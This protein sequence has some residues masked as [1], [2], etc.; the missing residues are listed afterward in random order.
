MSE[1]VIRVFF[2]VVVIFLFSNL[3]SFA[4]GRSDTT[5]V[6]SDTTNLDALFKKARDLAYDRN[7]AQARRICLKIL[8]KKPNYYEVRTFLGRTYAW[9]KQYDNAR[10]ELSRVL[11]EKE[12]DYEALNALFDVEFWTESYSVAN[13]YLKIALGYYPTSEELLIKKANLQIKLEEK[14]DA[15]L[16]LRR[17]LDIN[18]GNKE[19]ISIMN[20]LEGRKLNNNFQTNFQVDLYDDKNP[21]QLFYAQIGRNF[22]FGSLTMRGNLADKF[23]KQGF[24]YELESYA[25]ITRKLYTN[26]LVGFSSS[27]IFPSEKYLVELYQKLP[28]GF[29]VSL[30][31]RYMKYSKRSFGYTASLSNYYKDYY[32]SVRT[33]ISPKTDSTVKTFQLDKTSVSVIGTIRTYFGDS[34]NYLGLKI[35]SGRSPEE[36]ER[37]DV[38][39]FL[40]SYSIG[41][42]LQKRAIGRWLIKMD[43]TFAKENIIKE[44][45]RF[46]RRF[47]SGVT[48]K[49]VF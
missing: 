27:T 31:A 21:Q 18:P 24:Q 8:E 14:D 37:L 13:D 9:D 34:D 38:A 39:L 19:A 4:Q 15:A 47:S 26:L 29:E 36:E 40:P 6:I 1:K 35:G 46:T 45:N 49:T 32:F 11:I 10:T 41:M 16:T 28:K 17:V 2:S 5:V 7:Y 42:E 43:V 23:G 44:E 33:F 30:G 25:H 3:A 12:N 20:S 48:L 22:S